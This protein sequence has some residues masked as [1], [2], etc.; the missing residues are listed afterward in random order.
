[1]GGSVALTAIETSISNAEKWYGAYGTDGI[2]GVGILIDQVDGTATDNTC[3]ESVTDGV[4]T[5]MN[6]ETY[7][8]DIYNY[9]DG[10]GGSNL[11]LDA[12]MTLNP[13]TWPTADYVFGTNVTV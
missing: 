1:V 5:D 9:L 3:V 13:G 10:T 12:P 6:C 8:Q 2:D 11:G 4:D 7:Y